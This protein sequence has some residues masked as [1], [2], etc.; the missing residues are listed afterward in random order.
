MWYSTYTRVYVYAVKEFDSQFIS[1]YGYELWVLIYHYFLHHCTI[2]DAS[3][4]LNTLTPSN[5]L[6]NIYYYHSI[7]TATKPYIIN[8]IMSTWNIRF[9]ELCFSRSV[10]AIYNGW[11]CLYV[12]GTF[13]LFLC[14]TW[15]WQYCFLFCPANGGSPGTSTTN[16]P[17]K[18]QPHHDYLP[19]TPTL[20]PFNWNIITV[21]CWKYW[22]TIEN[23]LFS[24]KKS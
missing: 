17:H 19:Q 14:V 8:Y 9:H 23:A 22:L 13:F 21:G 4:G 7:Y 10:F 3:L 5:A 15:Q 12:V 18:Y 11:I 1:Y 24:F 20:Y 2:L 6:Y 16:N